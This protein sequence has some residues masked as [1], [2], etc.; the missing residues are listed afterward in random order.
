MIPVFKSDSPAVA[1]DPG[2]STKVDDSIPSP[3]SENPDFPP[4][5]EGVDLSYGMAYVEIINY[6]SGV[7]CFITINPSEEGVCGDNW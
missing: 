3:V 1:N 2:S 7:V 6:H 4:P 5:K